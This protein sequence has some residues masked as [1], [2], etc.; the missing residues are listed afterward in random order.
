MPTALRS[1]ITGGAGFVG[2]NLIRRL[3]SE[4]QDVH[5]FVRP[6][7]RLGRWEGIRDRLHIHLGD[8][9]DGRAVERALMEATPD[10]V[11]HLASTPFN[12]DTIPAAEHA[13][14]NVLGSVHV[15]QAAQAADVARVVVAGT[16]AE[17]GAGHT[18]AEDSRLRPGT[19]LGA[20]KAAASLLA[21]SFGLARGL[22]TVVL[23]LFTPF[24]PWESPRRLVP[25]VIQAGL[26]GRD[27]PMSAGT[28]ER[29]FVF[30]DDVV[31]ALVEASRH[32]IRPGAVYNIGS[33]TPRTVRE[34]VEKTLDLMGNPCRALVGKLP[35]RPD[36]ILEMS[37]DISAAKRDFN[38]CPKATLEG[39]LRRTIDWFQ[40]N[41]RVAVSFA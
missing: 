10:L 25:Q 16:G 40:S 23:R 30:V 13:A 39:G 35:M 15:F 32:P 34:V 12:P 29:D 6:T 4:G 19:I 14:V 31:D 5:A 21:Q 3:V 20:T 24:G 17:Y 36:E 1:F 11:Y 7:S 18:L 26:E 38:W 41:R 9:T 27:F 2:A 28:Q 8:V 22:S 33:G 37:A